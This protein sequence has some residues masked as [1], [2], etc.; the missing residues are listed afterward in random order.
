M[1]EGC[2]AAGFITGS[3]VEM[4]FVGVSQ[5]EKTVKINGVSER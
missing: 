4:R 2:D 1:V 5:E 3:G